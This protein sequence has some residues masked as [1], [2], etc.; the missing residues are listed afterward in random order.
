MTSA[1][2]TQL[3]TL[4]KMSNRLTCMGSG[5]AV[6]NKPNGVTCMVM[7]FISSRTANAAD[8]DDDC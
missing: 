3:Q 6:T 5:N 8:N 4:A 2:T 7:V 1:G